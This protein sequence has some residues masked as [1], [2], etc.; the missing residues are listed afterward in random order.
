MNGEEAARV[1]GCGFRDSEARGEMTQVLT[2]GQQSDASC[3][4]KGSGGDAA[5]LTGHVERRE[6][7]LRIAHGRTS[8]S[9]AGRPA[10]SLLKVIVDGGGQVTYSRS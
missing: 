3:S 10:Q 6:I 2:K 5:I 4:A 8:H 1:Y 9:R 7:I